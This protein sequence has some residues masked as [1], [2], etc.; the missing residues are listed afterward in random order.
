[1]FVGQVGVQGK[2]L[3]V[4]LLKYDASGNLLWARTFAGN[5]STT[6]DV[7]KAI[8]LDI[9][10][11]IYITGYATRSD[12]MTDIVILKYDAAGTKKW[13]RYQDGA[14]NLNAQ[15][16]AL[17]IDP[18]GY[19]CVTGYVTTSTAGT[20]I[21]VAKY[22]AGGYNL[23]SRTFGGNGNAEDKAFGI[24]ADQLNVYVTGYA[25]VMHADSANSDCVT[26]KYNA[27]GGLSWSA[28]FNGEGNSEDKAF[29]I[30]EDIDG[31][32]YITGYSSRVNQSVMSTD[33]VT[34]RYS[35]SGSQEWVTY[36]NGTVNGNDNAAALALNSSYVFVAGSSRGNNNDYDYATI[37]Y[38]KSSGSEDAVSRYSMTG[39]SQDIAEDIVAGSNAVYVTGFSEL[40]INAPI[41][42]SAITTLSFPV[43]RSNTTVSTQFALY[44]NYP[45]P[46]NPSTT[47]SFDVST[48][49]N[50]KIVVYDML[51]RV[52]STLVS[53]YLNAGSYDVVF[54]ASNF[55]SG[56]YFYELTVN[57]FRD[58]KKMTLVK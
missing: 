23:W 29:G 14:S 21:I 10:G 48:S 43:E 55:A 22:T 42:P 58:I 56:I 15:G 11:N 54:N 47:I 19:I 45:N 3:D 4:G 36:Y 25:S 17:A 51:G 1:M 50:V 16:T 35:S 9:F 53:K 39:N 24:A 5:D 20:D 52:V 31:S 8:S 38:M 26:L 2:S 32:I 44:Q 33:Y 41:A 34:I 49:S 40:N 18:Y 27:W 37:R 28:F 7:G 13:E 46:F 30:A 6:P 57:G 12:G